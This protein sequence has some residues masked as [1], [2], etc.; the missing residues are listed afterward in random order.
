MINEIIEL[1]PKHFRE[2]RVS[3]LEP[4]GTG[5]FPDGLHTASGAGELTVID[6]NRFDSNHGKRLGCCADT[7]TNFEVAT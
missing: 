6:G 2:R 1:S 7:P 3:V 4:D 5:L